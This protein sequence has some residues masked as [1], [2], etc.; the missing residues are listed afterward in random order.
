MSYLAGTYEV[1]VIGGGHAGIEAALAAARLGH[2][3]LMITTNLDSVGNMPC[4]PSIGG[5]AKGQL[6]R[7]IDALGGEMG[8]AADAC[9]IQFRMLN[10]GKG[11]AVHSPRAQTPG[12]KSVQ[13]L[14]GL[15]P[16]SGHGQ[17]VQILRQALFL[18]LFV[19]FHLAQLSLDI[20][21]VLGLDL[22]LLPHFFRKRRTARVQR[23]QAVIADLGTP[24]QIA[25][26]NPLP[27][28]R[29]APLFQHPGQGRTGNRGLLKPADLFCRLVIV[30]LHLV[31]PLLGHQTDGMAQGHQTGVRIVLTK[32]QPVFRTGSH[33][34]IR[35]VGALGDDIID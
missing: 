2:R 27:Y 9:G 35:L 33:H 1:V 34:A 7:E 23:S 17:I 3:T 16:Q 6:V 24:Q 26:Q 20:P 8:R 19:F 32:Q 18:Q 25:E 12:P 11:P 22:H 14:P 13:L 4:N 15:Q 28:R 31:Q 30:P 10:R 5:T 21:L 29:T